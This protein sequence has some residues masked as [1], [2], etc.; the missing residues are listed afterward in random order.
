MKRNNTPLPLPLFVEDIETIAR[1]SIE[2]KIDVSSV[3]EI[4][5]KVIDK[6]GRNSQTEKITSF[7]TELARKGFSINEAIKTAGVIL[8]DDYPECIKWVNE[9]AEV[10]RG[11][12]TFEPEKQ[13]VCVGLLTKISEALKYYT[14]ELKELYEEY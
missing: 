11:S 3:T 13:Y 2:T 9:V 6:F 12:V 1:I 8:N 7:A 5:T 4:Y 14:S 10:I